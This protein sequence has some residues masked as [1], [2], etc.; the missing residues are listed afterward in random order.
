MQWDASADFGVQ[1][2]TLV[3]LAREFAEKTVPSC[4]EKI[5]DLSMAF[6]KDDA[7]VLTHSYSRVVMQILLA[8][9]RRGNSISVIVTE[10]RPSGLGLKTYDELT[11]AGI[12]TTVIGDAA[13]AY[14]GEKVDP[15]PRRRRGRVRERRPAQLHRHTQ[16]R[17]R[18]QGLPE[19]VLRSRRE[20]SWQTSSARFIDDA[21]GTTPTLSLSYKFLRI[22]PLSQFDLPTPSAS[23]LHAS[24]ARPDATPTLSSSASAT[25]E[26]P[27]KD[28][29]RGTRLM[30]R[31]MEEKNPAVDYTSPDLV[32][33]LFSDV[34]VLTPSGVGDALLAVYGG[35]AD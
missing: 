16:P 21:H 9:A 23:P 31:E 22:F 26:D 30:T 25:D 18:R 12:P 32:T 19:T 11:S 34:G 24:T 33:F 14:M 2:Q 6:I 8:A 3:D 17:P 15:R 1:K 13:T 27:G 20:V 29:L 35:N 5:V 7:V 4:R 28:K 10:S